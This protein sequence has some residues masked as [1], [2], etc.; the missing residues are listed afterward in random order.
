LPI[1]PSFQKKRKKIGKDEGVVVWGPLDPPKR[2]GIRG[3]NVAVDWDLC[4]GCGVC[5]EICPAQV[6]ERRETAEHPTSKWKPLPANAA[7]CICCYQCEKQCPARAIR[8]VFGGP[9]S[10]LDM[11]ASYLVMA[12]LIG[13]PLYGLVFGPYFGLATPF[14]VGWVILALG[15]PFFFSPVLYLKTRGKP[16]KG[17]TLMDTTVVVK[18]GTY[19]IVRHPQFLGA[20]LTVCASILISQHWLFALIGIFLVGV[21]LRW[22]REEEENLLIRFKD[23]YKRYM[24]KV[25]RMNFLLGIIRLLR[26]K[27]NLK[28]INRSS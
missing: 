23:E 1:D 5:L 28:L 25:P 16:A 17:K 27:K 21:T 19:G 18:S 14:F 15:L 3:S 24:E 12:Q 26:R 10:P 13:G 7:K 22:I 2:L 4:N 20:L 6:Y 11:L 8:V 9:Q